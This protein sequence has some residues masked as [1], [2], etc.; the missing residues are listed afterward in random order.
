MLVYS[1]NGVHVTQ[2]DP[3]RFIISADG[4]GEMLLVVLPADGRILVDDK[5][6]EGLIKLVEFRTGRNKKYK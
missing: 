2:I 3:R 1:K 5:Y 6:M 4:Y